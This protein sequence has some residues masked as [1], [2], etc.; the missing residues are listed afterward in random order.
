QTVASGLTREG[1]VAGTPT[2]MS[3]EQ[4][5]GES[6]LDARTDVYSLGATL[7]EALTGEIPFRGAPHL[8]LRRVIEEDPRPPR[9]YS[10]HVPRD[11]ETICLKAMA[12]EPARRY[13]TAGAMAGDLHRWLGGEPILARPTGR[14]ERGV[15]WCPRNPRVAGLAASLIATLLV[16]FIAVVWQWRRAER[17]AVRAELNRRRSEA[18]LKDAQASFERARRAVDQFYTRF[19]E[20]GVLAVPGLEKVR[21]DVLGEMIQYYKDF[22]DQ[23]RNDPALRLELAETCVRIGYLTK[24]QG[25]K[26]D[27]LVVL[28]QALQYFERLPAD[29]G[30]DR[31]IQFGLYR[32]L[33]AIAAVESDL[34]DVESARRDYPRG[35]GVL[36]R[37]VQKEPGNLQLKRE[38]AAVLGNFA[39]LSLIVKDKTQARRAYLQALEIQK[40]LVGQD[41]AE[42][43]FKNDLALT[44]HNLAFLANTK[45]EE[46]ALLEQALALRKQLVEVLPG[47]PVFR[48]HLARTYE[49]LGRNQLS[50]G[51]TQDALGSLRESRALLHQVVI[52]QP[53]V[54]TYQDN[55][56]G[57]CEILGSTLSTLGQHREAREAYQEARTLYQ[58]LVRS[59][60][61]NAR[62]KESL[63]GLETMLAES[64]KASKPARP[65][66]TVI[67]ESPAGTVSRARQPGP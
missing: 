8:V 11:L 21:R 22:L 7:Y 5:R 10:D 2:Y 66:S 14:V 53:N 3:P 67:S 40:D 9:Q 12:R 44:Y 39:N 32:C 24:D 26:V 37:I 62:Y 43:D 48:R 42:V 34:G 27:A 19:Y 46:R 29:Q 15:L 56:A 45:Q 4:A 13:Q 55:L 50:L 28:R 38:L 49:S 1:V 59:N 65:G 52:E 64:E 23:H 6:Q 58:R 63:L 60:S 18:S 57:A 35:F 47:N 51:Q 20:E 17:N 16:G 33:H 31:R 61:E 25:N 41:P 30:D 36:E 54:T